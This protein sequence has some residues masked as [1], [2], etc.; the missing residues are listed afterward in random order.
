[1]PRLLLAAF[2]VSGL[3][4]FAQQEPV[5]V[6]SEPHHHHVIDNMFVRVYD[7]TVEPNESTLM[8]HHGHDYLGIFLGDSKFVNKKQ[9]GQSSSASIGDGEVRF[10][11]APVVHA[12]EDTATK[13]FRN[14]TIEIM[15]PTTHEKNCTESCEIPVPCAS[16]DKAGCVSVQKLMSADQWSVTRITL[17]PGS[18]YPQHTHLANFLVV[19]LT[20][21]DMKMRNQNGPETEVHG[22]AGEVR[23]NNPM[24]HTI[25]NVGP[26]TAKVVVLE[27]RGRPAGEG[28]ESMTPEKPGK[29]KPHDHH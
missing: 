4:C 13:P 11:A 22:K 26:N 25:R 18:T 15:Q 17:P 16:K 20:D 2:L 3:A 27:F 21:A 8:H 12:V 6:S 23:W 14:I 28:S 7:V 5:D 9:D 19:P 1:M 29:H 10:A 24:V